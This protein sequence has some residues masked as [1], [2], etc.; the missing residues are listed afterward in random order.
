MGPSQ[1]LQSVGPYYC[2]KMMW[3]QRFKK[4]CENTCVNTHF[5][6][7]GQIAEEAQQ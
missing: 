6:L 4:C 7:N 5:W 1:N 2:V 3:K